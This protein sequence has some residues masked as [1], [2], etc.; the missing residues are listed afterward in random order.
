MAS[1]AFP[2]A[3]R[4]KRT[5]SP[6]STEQSPPVNQGPK[7]SLAVLG[8]IRY[9][10]GAKLHNNLEVAHLGP[11][12][13]YQ[14]FLDTVKIGIWVLSTRWLQDGMSNKPPRYVAQR[15]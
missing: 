15:E 5:S 13:L 7:S 4:T 3:S 14:P 8:L 6:T 10:E 2:S 12:L 11:E 1:C 9:R